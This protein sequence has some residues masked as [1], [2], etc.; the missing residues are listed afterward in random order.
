VDHLEVVVEVR[1]P[2]AIRLSAMISRFKRR[3]HIL[4]TNKEEIGKHAGTQYGTVHQ[5]TEWNEGFGG[6]EL[7]I[8]S[9]CD[10]ND[11][12]N[13][14]HGDNHRSSVSFCLV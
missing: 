4:E 6:K 13:D 10:E 7:L 11:A 5:E 3:G 12:T 8:A 2:E 14:E 1:I 9:E